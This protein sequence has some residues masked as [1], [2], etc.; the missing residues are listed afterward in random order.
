MVYLICNES[1]PFL[2][3][4]SSSTFYL[5]EKRICVLKKT[6]KQVTRLV[7]YYENEEFN[8]G[9]QLTCENK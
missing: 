2:A 1:F 5:C 6:E 4:K 7:F 8:Q 3:T 9:C